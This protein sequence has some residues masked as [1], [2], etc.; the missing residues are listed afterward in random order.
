M[1]Y[2]EP[3]VRVTAF[4][5]FGTATGSETWS[6]NFKVGH[7]TD[8][9]N[10]AGFLPAIANAIKPFHT[11]GILASGTATF[12][13]ELH[14]AVIGTDG[15]YVGGDAQATTI[16]TYPTPAAGGSVGQM[17]WP[18]ACVLSLRVSSLSRGIASHGRCFWPAVGSVAGSATGRFTQTYT[19]GVAAAAKTMFDTV[20]TQAVATFGPGARVINSS[21]RG[22]GRQATVT[23]ILVGNRP[24]HQERR[25]NATVEAYSSVTLA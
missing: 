25:E 11:N 17:P 4:G 15:K 6:T 5:R 1:A 10:V 8:T 18:T 23:T 21:P 2:P 22:A 9:T 7:L 19:D 24:D 14:G 3:F 13:T 16:Y 20:N 12:L